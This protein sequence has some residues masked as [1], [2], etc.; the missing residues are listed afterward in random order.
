MLIF[1]AM[2][3]E[4]DYSLVLHNTFHLPAKT[5][6]FVSYNSEDELPLLLDDPF[7]NSSPFLSIGEGSNMLFVNDFDGVIFHSCIHGITIVDDTPD[8]VVLRVG[9]AEHWD[10]VVEYAVSAGWGGIENLSAIP[11]TAG[12]AVV[13][14]IGAYG[15][16]IKDVIGTVEAVH[17]FTGRKQVFSNESCRFAYRH[18]F[19]K[20]QDQD[21][22]MIT[23]IHVRLQK[24]PRQFKL[25][26]GQMKK[27]LTGQPI[28]L[29]TVREAIMTLRSCLLPDPKA[30]G[31]AGSFFTN[32]VIPLSQFRDLSTKYPTIPFYPTSEGYVKIP[33]GWLIEYCGFK[34]KRE[35]NVGV[36]EK[37]ALVLVNFGGASGQE[38]ASFAEKIQRSVHE[39]FNISLVPEVRYII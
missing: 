17:R 9:A 33:A 14:N 28:S 37:Q 2:R 8:T 31:N 36:Y 19:F 39:K 15:V 4:Q 16:E 20:S 24:S 12:A 25:D 26:Y 7:F 21:Q 13:Q 18:S 32:P 10:D 11:G 5:R 22:Y 35:G 27:V 23:A 3:I 34:G 30:L 1:F 29:Q 6:W 38:I